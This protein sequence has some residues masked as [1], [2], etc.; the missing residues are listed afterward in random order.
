MSPF[1]ATSLGY[2]FTVEAPG[3]S[4][5]ALRGVLSLPY[6]S[7]ASND[8]LLWQWPKDI[9][10]ILCRHQLL[11]DRCRAGRGAEVR[12]WFTYLEDEVLEASRRR[13]QEQ[14]AG[15]I[16]STRKPCAMLRG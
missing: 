7:Q 8:G 15:T 9:N 5:R 14:S 10:V 11:H 1:L 2:R 6:T 12:R 16:P 4:P 13:E 3:T